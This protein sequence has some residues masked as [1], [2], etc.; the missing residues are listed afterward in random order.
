MSVLKY[1]DVVFLHTVNPLRCLDGTQ[2][3]QLQV[4]LRLSRISSRQTAYLSSLFFKAFFLV[5]LEERLKI[6]D[7]IPLLNQV[8]A[9]EKWN[10][11][12]AFS[13]A[14]KQDVDLNALW[15]EYCHRRN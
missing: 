11:G 7:L 1:S 12:E 5:W 15:K 10:D 4:R 9:T 6:P 3:M 14:A 13:R 8:L 2:A